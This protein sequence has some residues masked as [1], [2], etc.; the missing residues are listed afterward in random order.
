MAIAPA[1]KIFATLVRGEVY[2]LY[3]GAGEAK[4]FLAGVA[5]EVT[6]DERKTLQTNA[7]DS[8]N[9]D[10]EAEMRQKFVFG[11]GAPVAARQRTRRPDVS[12]EDVDV[13]PA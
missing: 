3:Q 8:I 11:D 1:T 4:T 12:L 9:S 6:P 10:G 5:K 2:V 13:D 7:V